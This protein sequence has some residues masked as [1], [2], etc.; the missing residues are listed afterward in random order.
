MVGGSKGF[1]DSHPQVRLKLWV[2]TT[3][4]L[5]DTAFVTTICL[6]GGVHRSHLI[7]LGFSFHLFKIYVLWIT[8]LFTF[9]LDIP[10]FDLKA[11]IL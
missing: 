6:G 11:L 3:I 8:V 2:V 9:E 5:Q 1:R 4:C 10:E 7:R